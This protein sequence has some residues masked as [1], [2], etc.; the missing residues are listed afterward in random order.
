MYL[1][2]FRIPVMLSSLNNPF[3]GLFA[4]H[5]LKWLYIILIFRPLCL[6]SATPEQ[7][8]TI[9]HI[10][11]Y[12][13]IYFFYI[14]VSC[15]FKFTP[16]Q[17]SYMFVSCRAHSAVIGHT[18]GWCWAPP[19]E[20]AGAGVERKQ[21]SS[22]KPRHINLL[23]GGLHPSVTVCWLIYT[24]QTHLCFNAL[25]KRFNISAVCF[26]ATNGP[27]GANALKLC[28]SEIIYVHKSCQFTSLSSSM[29]H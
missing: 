23:S 18:L 22:P 12:L 1:S 19:P 10:E 5:F 24:R 21:Q 9:T 29:V 16:P 26:L 15:L 2:L 7:L 13:F 3:L 17:A 28:S 20:F 25:I 27:M 14:C 4:L 11:S 8:Q 6:T